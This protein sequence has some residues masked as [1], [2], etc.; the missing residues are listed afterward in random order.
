MLEGA[1]HILGYSSRTCKELVRGDMGY[2]VVG[3]RPSGNG[4]I[5]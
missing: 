5:S 4:G 3:I 1:K 2:K